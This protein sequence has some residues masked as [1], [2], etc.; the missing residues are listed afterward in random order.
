MTILYKIYMDT[1]VLNF[2]YEEADLEKRKITRR[3]FEN[4][5]NGKIKVYLSNVVLG[6]IE[7]APEE[8]RKKLKILLRSF[9]YTELKADKKTVALA[10]MYVNR[11]IIPR[12]YYADALH[13]AVAVINRIDL[14]VSWNFRHIVKA[15]TKIMVNKINRE[16]GL[17]EL[18]ICSP[19][20]VIE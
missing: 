9:P 4:I 2:Y 13:I 16:Q 3:V 19:C 14:L 10:D 8:K 6:E 15:R 5:R 20:E 11:R 12:R 1:S 7:I 18:I 17:K